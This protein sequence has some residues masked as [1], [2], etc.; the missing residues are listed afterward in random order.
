L[1]LTYTSNSIEGSTLTE[2]ETEAVLFHNASPADRTVTEV[3][4]AKNHQTALLYLF[5]HLEASEGLDEP[6]ILRLHSTLMNG[7]LPDAGRYRSHAVRIVGTNIPTSNSLSVPAHMGELAASLVDPSADVLARVAEIHARFEQIHPFS[8]GNGRV[9]RLLMHAMLL[10]AGFPPAVIRPTRKRL[11]HAA[12]RQ[13]Q[14]GGD[15]SLLQD[16]LCD[17]VLEGHALLLA[18]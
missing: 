1:T 14:V 15:N 8:D 6:L 4:E 9:G 5:E 7:I 13:A 18:E 10:R 2:D 3:L 16:F 11:Y 17:A 12:L